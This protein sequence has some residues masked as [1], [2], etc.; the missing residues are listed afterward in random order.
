MQHSIFGWVGAMVIA[1]EVAVAQ[2][3]QF[4]IQLEARPTLDAAQGRAQNYA[5]QMGNVNGFF[6][7][8]GWYGIAV[9]PFAS[10]D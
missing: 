4:F 5:G 9:G 1:A 10:V 6:L 2:Q 7:G 8:R 3:G